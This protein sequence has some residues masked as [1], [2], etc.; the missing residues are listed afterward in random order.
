MPIKICPNCNERY[1][2]SK[3]SGDYVHQCNSENLALDQEDVL[4][5][6]NY[7]NEKTGE[8]K[9]IANVNLQG[10]A[11]R[12][13]GTT[14]GLESEDDEFFTKRGN[15]KSTYRQRQKFTYIEEN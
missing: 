6:G 2:V 3:N 8:K 13:K 15:R 9:E 4:K 1:F 7:T 5:I 12:L 11:N 10:S 14:A